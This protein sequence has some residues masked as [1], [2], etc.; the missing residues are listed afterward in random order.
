M[1]RRSRGDRSQLPWRNYGPFFAH[2]GTDNLLVVFF[3][4]PG[5]RGVAL[6]ARSKARSERL[7]ISDGATWRDLSKGVTP[8]LW[9]DS[10]D[11]HSYYNAHVVA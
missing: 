3:A 10:S 11:R 8:T 9:L 4:C 1:L 5:E 7:Q 2:P 6:L